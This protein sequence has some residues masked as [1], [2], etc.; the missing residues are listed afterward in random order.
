MT[1]VSAHAMITRA[2]MDSGRYETVTL[3]DGQGEG[4]WGGVIRV[5]DNHDDLMITHRRAA[6]DGKLSFK[7]RGILWYLLSKPADWVVRVQDLINE[8]PG[9]KELVQSGLRELETLGYLRRV[10]LQ[11]KQGQFRGWGSEVSALP[12]FKKSQGVPE[13]SG[14]EQ[15][16]IVDIPEPPPTKRRPQK[17]QQGDH[18]VRDI[19][20][21]YAGTR[22]QNYQDGMIKCQMRDGGAAARFATRLADE[23]WSIEQIRQCYDSLKR[24]PF[25]SDKYLSLGT[26]YKQ[27]ASWHQAHDTTTT[28]EEEEYVPA[29]LLLEEAQSR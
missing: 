23:G 19:L 14:V 6:Q 9:G 7:A 12:R 28:I 22:E 11:D 25:W 16:S 10:R 29:A 27:I 2:A 18:R 26:V 20:A 24:Q 15:L 3:E 5:Y 4:D 1:I 13:D 17:K 8:S 21:A